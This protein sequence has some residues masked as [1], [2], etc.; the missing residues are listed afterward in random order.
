MSYRHLLAPGRI[1]GLELKNRIILAAMGSN[2]A[3]A[4]GTCGERIQAYYEE[5]ARGGTGLLIMETSTVAWPAGSTMPNMVG[6][7]EDRFMPGL[8][9]LAARVHRHGAKI[10]A[11]LNHGGKVAQEDVAAGR[12]ML[13]PSIPDKGMSDMFELLTPGELGN[14][15]KAAGPD[16]KGPR[17]HEMTQVDID[18]L[19]AQFASA[20]QR[21]KEA[22]FDAV[23]IHAGH[24]YVISSFLSPAVNKRQDN[25]GGSPENRARLLCEVIEGVRQAVG[26]DF[27]ILVRFDAK[28]FRVEGGIELEDAIITAGLA[29]QAGADALDVSAYGNTSIGIA[30]TEAPL[31]HQPAGFVDFARTIKKT[32]SI[33]V[34]A[35]GRIELD[36]AEKG[37]A[38]SDFDFVAMGRKLLADPDLPN[39][40]A[41]GKADTIRPCIYC[42]VCVS[43]I[44]INDAMSCAVNP[45]CGREHELNVIHSTAQ[46]QKRVLVI[47]GGP[48]GLEAARVSAERGFDVGLW[49]K[50]K[51]LGGTAR[52]AALAYEPNGRLVKHLS[53]QVRELPIDIQLGKTATLEAI[54]A[55]QADIVIVATGANRA[56]PPIPGKDQRHVFDGNEL[57]G[58]LFGTDPAAASKLSL[59][60]RLVV[61]MGQVS[62][63]LRSISALRLLSKVWMPLSKRIVLIGGGLVGL[64][65]AEYLVARGRQVTVLE[66]SANLGAELSIVRRARVV[67]ELRE[68]GVAMHRDVNIT[69]IGHAGIDFKIGG[70]AQHVPCDQV[71][72]STGAV[73]DTSLTDALNSA[74]IQAIGVGDCQ[75]VGYIEGAILG[76]RTAALSIHT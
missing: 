47:G 50:E 57:R 10:A 19:V 75:E 3:N 5:R 49:E 71:I 2:F 9:Q 14:F 34:I 16:G 70:N 56:A 4:D 15:V 6:F 11:Q 61:K 45:A 25:Y 58:L 66:P 40:I 41:L 8:T 33:P 24:G 53:R 62:Q 17:Y 72:I 26:A 42:Y 23:E 20:A 67:H 69:A 32:V 21:A 37:L 27:P 28:E 48:G 44:F 73:P 63:L 51:D 60:Q 31:V 13:V 46:Q 43:K 36:V 52:I 35:V 68:H 59:F 18:E 1:A 39:K 54:K 29:E 55:H 12:P 74:G 7:S 38:N 64:E 30:F 76:G 22:N 65:L